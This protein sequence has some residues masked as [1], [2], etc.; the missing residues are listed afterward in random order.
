V[1]DR[2]S[3]PIDTLRPPGARRDPSSPG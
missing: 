2:D 3:F 1:Q